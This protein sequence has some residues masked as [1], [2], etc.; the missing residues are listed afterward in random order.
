MKS[1]IPI[2]FPP[3]TACW[4]ICDQALLTPTEKE[5][6]LMIQEIS[7]ILLDLWN[8]LAQLQGI[9]V[10]I[11]TEREKIQITFNHWIAINPL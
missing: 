4:K 10:K 9:L 2:P 6:D 7:S 11:I 1:G 3:V 5:L 8:V